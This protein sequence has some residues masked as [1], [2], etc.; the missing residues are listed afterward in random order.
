MSS[1]FGA[2]K[3]REYA[4]VSK[5]KSLY[6]PTAEVGRTRD[7]ELENEQ[8]MFNA[9]HLMQ[10]H[11]RVFNMGTNFKSCPVAPFR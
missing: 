9:I 10:K 11:K 3:R 6:P 5:P 7:R 2:N 8:R 4:D 1:I